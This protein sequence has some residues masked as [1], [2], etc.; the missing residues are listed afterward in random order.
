MRRFKVA[1]FVKPSCEPLSL[2]KKIVSSINLRA[3][4]AVKVN[5]CWGV[6][7][8]VAFVEQNPIKMVLANKYKFVY[9]IEG[10]VLKIADRSFPMKSQNQR[11]VLTFMAHFLHSV[12]N[13]KSSPFS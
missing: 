4:S 3:H 13:N 8:F 10:L 11:N 12:K 6:M 2:A 5:E 1:A 7:T 9:L